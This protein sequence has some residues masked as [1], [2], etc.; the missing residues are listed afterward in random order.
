LAKELIAHSVEHAEFR[1]YDVAEVGPNDIQIRS[2]FGAM[3][4][5][6]ELAGFAGYSGARGR[7]DE[8]LGLFVLGDSSDGSPP[9]KNS[10]TK[11]VGNMIVGTV[12]AIGS[13]VE[14]FTEGD[15]VA[16]HAPFRE[17]QIVSSERCWQIPDG[18]SWKS[19]VC[20]DPAQFALGAVRDGNVRVGDAVAVFGLGAIGLMAIQ[21]AKAS[22]AN[23]VIGIDLAEGRRTV[24]LE[25]GADLVLDPA[26]VDVGLEL[27]RAT[28]KRGVDVAI[29]YSGS[30]QAMQAALRGVAFG[31]T[32]VAGAFPPPYDAGLDFG[33]EAHMNRPNIVF[34]RAVSDPNRDHPRWDQLRIFEACWAMFE[35]GALSGDMIVDPVVP[36]AELDKAFSRVMSSPDEGIKLGCFFD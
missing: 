6:T 32:V 27:K 11:P 2:Q 9:A 35:S 28:S 21:V 20:L 34:S 17:E 31:G 25:C 22:G 14:G 30:A 29:E 19:A 33:A 18:I 15:T 13:S 12:T 4:H 16:A 26:S 7:F 1:D 23:P 10:K 36:F 5:G 24:G 8:E 3:K